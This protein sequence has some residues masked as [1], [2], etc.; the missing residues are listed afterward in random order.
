V[1][2]ARTSDSAAAVTTSSVSLPAARIVS[3]R[4]MLSIATHRALYNAT[5]MWAASLADAMRP[6]RNST[7]FHETFINPLK[8][9][10]RKQYEATLQNIRKHIPLYGGSQPVRL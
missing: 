2:A 3:Q 5:G 10:K 9:E 6:R 1:S 7:L 4:L 8:P